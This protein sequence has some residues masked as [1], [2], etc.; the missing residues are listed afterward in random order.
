MID[1]RPLLLH[2]VAWLSAAIAVMV[3]AGVL[4]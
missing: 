1:D 2:S 3:I 4:R